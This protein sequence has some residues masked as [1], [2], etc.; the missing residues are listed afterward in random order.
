MY[1]AKRINPSKFWGEAN[2]WND[3]SSFRTTQTKETLALIDI[4]LD[5]QTRQQT[6][7]KKDMT[8]MVHNNSDERSDSRL[9]NNNNNNNN[10][11]DTIDE[12]SSSSSSSL[13]RIHHKGDAT[14]AGISTQV[15]AATATTTATTEATL[16]T[17][18]GRAHV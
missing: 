14:T 11:K 18:I 10:N 17:Q 2:P 9:H 16:V 6:D 13:G 3:S 15:P 1:R 8:L 12:D 7:R 4:S 5:S